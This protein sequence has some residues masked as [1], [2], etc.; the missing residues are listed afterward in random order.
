VAVREG[1]KAYIHVI[2]L[3]AEE[4]LGLTILSNPHL[5]YTV[6]LSHN[7]LAVSL[8]P[9]WVD[10]YS[11]AFRYSVT[12]ATEGTIF[13][14]FAPRSLQ[15]CALAAIC[16]KLA[17]GKFDEA[18]SILK[19]R[20]DLEETILP[21][22]HFHPS[23][24][25]YQRLQSILSQSGLDSL[26]EAK[27]CIKNILQRVR[28]NDDRSFDLLLQ[29][30]HVLQSSLSLHKLEDV[31]RA[32][33]S[34]HKAFEGLTSLDDTKIKSLSMER[35]RLEDRIVTLQ[36]LQSRLDSCDSTTQFIHA[37]D[38]AAMVSPSD[39]L[40]FFMKKEL[41]VEAELA[42]QSKLKLNI[43]PESMVTALMQ[44]R[45]TTDPQN[46]TTF[47][48]EHIF[49]RLELNSELLPLLRAWACQT[50]DSLDEDPNDEDGLKKAI[51]LLK[52]CDTVLCWGRFSVS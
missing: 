46:Y 5:L 51:V 44:L 37:E 39:L 43:S 48:E 19:S 36:Y 24:L 16:C 41:F 9:F 1:D 45:S 29:I 17:L 25:N 12:T 35:K 23:E 33:Q 18:T 27:M 26:K 4:T 13:C 7:A 3:I 8:A 42:C 22:A 32:L 21:F 10:G 11:Y 2:Q 31:I 30:P 34:V 15:N 38:I 14:A 40:M 47:I 49:P 6:P 52:V 28:L 20:P 50:A